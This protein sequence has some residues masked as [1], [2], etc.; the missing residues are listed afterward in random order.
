MDKGINAWQYDKAAAVEVFNGYP[1]LLGVYHCWL[2]TGMDSRTGPAQTRYTFEDLAAFVRGEDLQV[3]GLHQL[4]ATID[5]QTI[6]MKT[7]LEAIHNDFRFAM[8][9]LNHKDAY[10]D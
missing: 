6:Q 4:A 3:L 8:N 5:S 7:W 1:N 2:T 10:D 9:V